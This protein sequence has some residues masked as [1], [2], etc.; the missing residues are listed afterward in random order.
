MTL[1][2]VLIAAAAAHGASDAI[3]FPDRRYSYAELLD[4]A[5]RRA[6]SLMALGVA[7]GDHVGLLLPT[8]FEF[9]EVMFGAALAGAVVVPVNCRYVSHE[10][11]YVI[12]NADLVTLVTTDR[13]TDNVNFIERLERALP[14][15]R[16]QE[17]PLSLRLEGAPKLRNIAVL[18]LEEHDGYVGKS[19][20]DALADGIADE[21]LDARIAATK[22][23]DIALILYTSGTTSSPKGCLIAHESIVGNS[24]ALGR[25]RYRLTHEDRFWSPL[26]IFHIAG[27]LPMVAIMDVGGA[28]LTM[29]HFSAGPALKMLEAERATATYPCFVTIMQDLISHPDFPKTD[30]SSVRLMNSSF[31]VQPPGIKEAMSAAMPHAIQVGTYGLTEASGTICTSRLD[32]PYEVRTTR[33]GA[34]LAGWEVRIANPETGETCAPGEIGEILARGPGMLKGYY[35]AP[36]K[37]AETIDRDGWLHTGDLGSLDENGNI[38]FHG[39]LKDMLKVGG[40]NVAAVEIESHIARHPAVKLAQVVGVPHERL[41]EVPAAF[42]ELKPG[43]HATEEEIIA[44]CRGEIASFKVPRYVRFVTE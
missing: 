25:D 1:G 27:I 19:R 9:I 28:Y 16:Q 14:G 42:V 3:V 43:C 34:P 12:E 7:K 36:E 2:Q 33:L 13:V 38:M 40:E 22:G 32:D 18:G 39:R 23:D 29:P 30:L 4:R 44:F 26:P 5:R 6:K 37:T 35:K 24:R 17:N 20:F 8:S 11:A 10:L 31:A 15:L 41:A 21:D